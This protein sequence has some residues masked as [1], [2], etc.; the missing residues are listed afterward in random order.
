MLCIMYI[1]DDERKNHGI[2]ME[3][4]PLFMAL[5]DNEWEITQYTMHTV[6]W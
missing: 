5:Y 6:K 1:H 3:N 4:F 2:K